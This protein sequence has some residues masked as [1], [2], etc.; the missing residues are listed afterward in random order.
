[1][2]AVGI[3]SM[4]Y[5]G[6]LA[7]EMGQGQPELRIQYSLGFTVISLFTPIIV[8][9]A[10]FYYFG[11]SK[12][13]THWSTFLGGTLTGFAVCAMHYLGQIRI[14]NYTTSY[15][16]GHVIGSVIVAVFASTVAL[17][18]FFYLTATWTD[19]I[20]KR[21][22]I[23][24]L[25]AASVSGMHWVAT[26]GCTYRFT[27]S[28]TAGIGAMRAHS[29]QGTA[30]V[31]ICMVSGPCIVLTQVTD[32]AKCIGCCTSLFILAMLG[33]RSR[34][35]SAD[36]AQQVVLACA[37]FDMDGK[38]MVTPEGVLPCQKITDSFTERVCVFSKG[39]KPH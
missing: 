13:V 38:V 1:M 22:L 4:H 12:S 26:V 19:N 3:W 6:N 36:R 16:V 35:L 7:I 14:M 11:T 27:T 31:V 17:G 8:L 2:G 32:H 34:K 39:W 30:T 9:S 23:A 25:M 33:Q 18:V 37:T 10:A 5:I 29:R 15:S 21:V 20:F 24:A 28:N